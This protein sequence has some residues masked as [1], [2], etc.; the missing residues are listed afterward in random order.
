MTATNLTIDVSIIIVNYN[1][2]VEVS[3]C[4]QSLLRQTSIRFDIW[5]VDNASDDG[6]VDAL[7]QRFGT[8][9]KLIAS[10]I[11]LGFGKANNLAA[12][13]ATGQYLY[14][15]NPDAQLQGS[16]SLR[17]L[18]DYAIANPTCGLIGTTVIDT[19]SKQRILPAYH[20]PGQK[21]LKSTPHLAHLPGNIAWIQGSSML[22]LKTRFAQLHGFDPDYFL[23]VEE[24]DLCLRVRKAGYKIAVCEQ[25]I[26]EHIGGASQRTEKIAATRLKKQHSLYIFY[27]KH[28]SR[29]D[30]QR[31]AKRSLL[32][33]RLKISWL[34]F[35]KPQS[36]AL[37][38]QQVIFQAARNF[39]IT[40][41][42]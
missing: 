1:T 33:S 8:K 13:H 40:I 29:R 26:V 25:V 34:T 38:R 7:Q 21:Q 19:N 36:V 32:H 10:S 15:I 30:C 23:Y 6:S 18:V 24:T 41:K 9:I 28:Y 2:R 12:L 20:Y 5:V 27:Q 17:I 3:D 31:L 11:N 39:L 42:C 4:I 16:Q 37:I 35:V 22:M 14:F